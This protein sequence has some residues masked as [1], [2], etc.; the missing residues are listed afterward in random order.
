MDGEK[1]I[2]PP[3]VRS[4]QKEQYSGMSE[5]K[6]YG[7]VGGPLVEREDI[8]RTVRPVPDRTVAQGHHH[9]EQKVCSDSA[10]R[11]QAKI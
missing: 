5:R 3:E 6:N 9:A 7:E 8:E 2:D 10:D 4:S 11:A 1:N